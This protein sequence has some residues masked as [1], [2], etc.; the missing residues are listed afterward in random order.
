MI[1]SCAGSS[2]K[3]GLRGR[4]HRKKGT[5]SRGN[6]RNTSFSTK[7][8]QCHSCG[9]YRRITSDHETDGS[10][11]ARVI[12]RRAQFKGVKLNAAYA[13]TYTNE[14]LQ[15]D[16]SIVSSRN[17]DNDSLSF[18]MA[19]LNDSTS[20]VSRLPSTLRIY[21]PSNVCSIV[22]NG[23]PY[24]AIKITELCLLRNIDES[25]NYPLE[26]KPSS[27]SMFHWWQ[28][29]DGDNSSHLL[30]LTRSTEITAVENSGRLIPI[31]NLDLDRSLH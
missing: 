27:V 2:S 24:S 18:G 21:D 13:N 16:E 8:A 11:K 14:N 26:P 4:D 1:S 7:E 23:A 19:K 29:G 15:K 12:P 25:N 17:V 10:L 6:N 20:D 9:Y 30:K 28:Y 3:R 31:T 5:Y 22:A